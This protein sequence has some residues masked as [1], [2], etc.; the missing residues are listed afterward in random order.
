MTREKAKPTPGPWK[1]GT[2]YPGRIIG[3]S[4]V[5][6]QTTQAIDEGFETAVEIANARLISAAP[7]MAVALANL[8]DWCR[9]HTGPK[10]TLELLT[11]AHNALVKAGERE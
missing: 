7:D 3:G 6:A 1:V 2:R 9:E 10:E 4:A 8:L 5:V 11:A